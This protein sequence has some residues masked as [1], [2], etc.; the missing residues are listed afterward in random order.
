MP[1]DEDLD[2]AKDSAAD[3]EQ[4]VSN[5]ARDKEAED[6]DAADAA[7]GRAADAEE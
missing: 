1:S 3:A 5:V 6:S 7:D 4:N 2:Q